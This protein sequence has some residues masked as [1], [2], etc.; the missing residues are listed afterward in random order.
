MHKKAWT[1]RVRWVFLVATLLGLFSA[2]QSYRLSSLNPKAR[3][4]GIEV[5]MIIILN[6]AFWYIPATSSISRRTAVS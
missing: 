3:L 4:D 2:A 5:G 1:P 6:L